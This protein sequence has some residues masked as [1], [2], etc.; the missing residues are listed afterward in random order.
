MF[1]FVF[2][3]MSEKNASHFRASSGALVN[4]RGAPFDARKKANIQIGK[5]CQEKNGL[6]D[7]FVTEGGVLFDRMNI[8]ISM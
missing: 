4:T 5:V 1:G 3:V 8:I 2:I 7:K 6:F